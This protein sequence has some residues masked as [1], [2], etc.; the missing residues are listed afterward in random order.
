MPIERVVNVTSAIRRL[1]HYST[2]YATSTRGTKILLGVQGAWI[3][4]I[5]TNSL[6]HLTRLKRGIIDRN[7]RRRLRCVATNW[8]SDLESGYC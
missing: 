5:V 1:A 2:G 4:V 8:L 7:P 6:D 3:R